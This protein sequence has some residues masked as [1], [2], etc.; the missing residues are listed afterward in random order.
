MVSTYKYGYTIE[1]MFTYG[2]KLGSKIL[3]LIEIV[4]ISYSS[5]LA[6]LSIES[7][8]ASTSQRLK[9]ERINLFI[10]LLRG[11]E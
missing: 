5:E 9:Q 6:I 11:A 4:F 2:I 8:I 1:Q 7:E 3:K 10:L